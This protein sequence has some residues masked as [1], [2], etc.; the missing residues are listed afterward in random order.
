MSRFQFS[1]VSLHLQ[2]TAIP[3]I[4]M[5]N[6]APNLV[7]VESPAKAKTIEKFLGKEFRVLSSYGH[8]R[9]LS[10][11]DMGVDIEKN[12][13]PD[14]I[15]P[16]DKENLV[17]E[18]K[19]AAKQATTVWLAS[20][21]D[22]E[23]E[24]IAWHLYEVL[25]LANKSTE[26]IV[27]HE[28]TP[29]AIQHAISSPRKID[30]HLVDA[31]QAR[32]VL[33]RIVGFKLSPVLWKQIKPQLSAGRVQSVAVRLVVDREHE[34]ASFE[35]QSSYKV[36]A[37]LHDGVHDP[38]IVEA[39]HTFERPEEAKACVIANRA[40]QMELID[41]NR[42]PGKRS[43][44]TPFTTST[45][46]QE[47]ARKLG[48][49]VSLT[50]RVAQNL[51]ESGYIT[52]MRTDSVNL[53]QLAL[54]TAAKVIKEQ[55]GEKYYK[56]RTYHTKTKG[57]QEAHEAI[58]PTYLD[59]DTVPGTAQEKRL[60][61]LIRMR[62]LACQMEDAQIE[63]TTL[64]FRSLTTEDK[65]SATGE[66]ILFDGFLAVYNDGEE[67]AT[68]RHKLPDLA[69]HS[70]LETTV[71]TAQERFSSP[72][73]RYSEASLVK[74]MEELGIGRPSTY[75]PTIQTIQNREYVRKGTSAGRERK[76]TDF[77]WR[78][79]DGK[80]ALPQEEIRK[81][82]AGGDKGRFKPT[83]IGEVVNTFLVEHFPTIVDYNFTAEV[84]EDFDR[85][86]AGEQEWRSSMADF[87][88]HFLPLVDE[89]MNERSAHTRGERLLGHDP[90]SGK[91]VTVRVGRYGPLV[92]IGT[93]EDESGVKPRFASLRQ[94]QSISTITL[95][96]ALALFELP[97]SLGT[98]EDKEVKVAI[99]RFG[100]YI[101]HDGK[102]TSLPKEIDP[103][104]VSLMQAIELIK[105]KREKEEKALILSF[106]EDADLTVREGRY[107]PYIKYKT[108]NIALPKEAKERAGQLTYAEC[109]EIVAKAPKTSTTKRRTKK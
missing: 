23:G 69:L 33:D 31:Q 84:E 58:R 103:M 35:S 97:R 1:P 51:Y 8:I 88:Q 20:D 48:F 29:E 62:T 49:S 73:P 106:E 41:K 57:A 75:A 55:W 98:F 24:A 59:R 37:E 104:E 53:S 17:A 105:A 27:F 60:Y 2:Y 95:E 76:L 86:A 87:C 7:I 77:V 102:F 65:F 61:E 79:S 15:I 85:I 34:I 32:R 44:S 68:E 56:R 28:I 50:M 83:D 82:R 6:Q 22:R 11:V 5:S 91:P 101:L 12:F 18:L 92:Q 26:R 39:E 54:N 67:Q 64:T 30:R 13:L 43:P 4:Y 45:L 71:L 19:K 25:G 42:R 93:S 36:L 99:G 109:A 47:A 16:S 40:A 80:E 38:F 96:E 63:R 94:E 66:V 72:P 3:I 9:D 78:A 108:K 81:E 10:K 70:K 107:G 21:E 14:Y 89:A 90:V 100:P 52:Y 74:K 46:Q